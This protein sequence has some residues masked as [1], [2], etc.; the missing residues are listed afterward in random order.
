M[1]VG[2]QR[3]AAA[4]LPGTHCIGDWV[5]PWAGLVWCGTS[6][7]PPALAHPTVQPVASSCTDCATPANFCHLIPPRLRSRSHTFVQTKRWMNA[8]G[9]STVEDSLSKIKSW[10]LWYTR[11]LNCGACCCTYWWVG[12]AAQY[13]GRKRKGKERKENNE[14]QMEGQ[15]RKERSTCWHSST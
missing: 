11:R 3:H 5:G 14:R 12:Y 7:L 15:S 9:P 2:G 8:T 4:A 10:R 6:R 1:G 13:L